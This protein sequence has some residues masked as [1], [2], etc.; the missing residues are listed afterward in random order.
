[1]NPTKRT[2]G[3]RKVILAGT[4][5][6]IGLTGGLAASSASASAQSSAPSNAAST[7]VTSDGSGAADS[8]T[9]GAVGHPQLGTPVARLTTEQIDCLTS[10]GITKPQ[11]E[12]TEAQ[13]QALQDAATACGIDLPTPGSFTNGAGGPGS[14]ANHDGTGADAQ[15]GTAS[16]NAQ[17]GEHIG[18]RLAELSTDQQDCLTSNGV[19]KPQGQPTEAQ[20]Q[21]LRDAAKAC[22][23]EI[24]TSAPTGLP[25]SAPTMA[26][27]STTAG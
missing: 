26:D 17:L 8:G 12:P 22:G 10:Q 14:I 7:A 2:S 18:R 6:L 3:L 19:T 16:S 15:A 9:T 24:P 11:G 1:M 27:A 5:G 25:T 13:R 20:R 23:I 4:V 21:A